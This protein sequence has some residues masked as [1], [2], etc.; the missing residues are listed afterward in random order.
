MN[1]TKSEVE[2]EFQCCRPCCCFYGL[3]PVVTEALE[4]DT[5]NGILIL[6]LASSFRLD[7]HAAAHPP[8]AL[9]T[10]RNYSFHTLRRGG[11]KASYGS[12]D[13]PAT[14]HSDGHAI[15]R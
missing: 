1:S 12:A 11:Q 14:R 10:S 3:I 6:L 4:I 13:T 8:L 5:T 7:L 9:T 15:L 2:D